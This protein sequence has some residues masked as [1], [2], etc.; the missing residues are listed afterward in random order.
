MNLMYNLVFLLFKNPVMV[1]QS[2]LFLGKSYLLNCIAKYATENGYNVCVSA[3]TGKLASRCAR[4]LPNCGCNTVHTNFHNPV[5]T[6]K[7]SCNTVNWNLSDVH[8]IIIDE[9]FIIFFND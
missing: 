8:V 9:V 2:F 5:G 7:S 4:D 3:P 1:I 6:N